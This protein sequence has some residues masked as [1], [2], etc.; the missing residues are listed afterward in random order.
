MTAVMDAMTTDRLMCQVDTAGD[1]WIW[2]G[3]LDD[4]GY[5]ICQWGGKKMFRAARAFYLS[6]KAAIPSGC[7][8]DHRCHTEDES[9]PGGTHCPHRACVNPEHLEPVLPRTNTMRSR[10]AVAAINARKTECVYGHPFDETNTLVSGGQ[11]YCR[12][13]LMARR[14]RV[15]ADGTYKAYQQAW[16]QRNKD[17]IAARRRARKAAP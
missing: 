11:R 1:C 7:H 15:K 10:T 9:C 3:F 2:L 16:Y 5:G 6:H 13:C 8:L 17:R 14:A 4:D 12:T